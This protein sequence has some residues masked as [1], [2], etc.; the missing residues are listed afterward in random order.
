MILKD[1]YKKILPSRIRKKIRL[2]RHPLSAYVSREIHIKTNNVVASGPFKGMKLSLD[3][4]HLAKFLGTYELEIHPVFARLSGFRFDQIINVGAAEGYYAVGMALKWPEATVYAFESIKA[5]HAQIARYASDNLVSNRV[6]IRGVCAPGDLINLLNP[7]KSTL[8]MLD[9]E[10]DEILLLVP[11]AIEGLRKTIILVELH[12]IFICG[13]ST[14]IKKR[15]QDTHDIYKYTGRL[16]TRGDFPLH[17]RYINNPFIERCAI[18]AMQEERSPQQEYF[19][20][21]PISLS[22]SLA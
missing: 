21:I 1:L 22:K 13:C 17:I 8:L 5:C 11:F 4:L 19:L 20:M 18:K 9:A 6:H 16:R 14:I 12:D 2:Y 10:G 7:D 3:E 15:F